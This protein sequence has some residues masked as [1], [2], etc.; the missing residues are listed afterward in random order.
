MKLRVFSFFFLIRKYNSKNFKNITGDSSWKNKCK[1]KNISVGF[2]SFYSWF[3]IESSISQSIYSQGND[4]LR[5]GVFP[6][7]RA[8][9]SPLFGLGRPFLNVSIWG[10]SH[11]LL[12]ESS[13]SS[14][15]S[16][17]ESWLF[18]NEYFL[19]FYFIRNTKKNKDRIFRN[20]PNQ[21]SCKVVEITWSF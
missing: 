9:N 12:L 13:L 16:S 21:K 2:S 3:Y 15:S 17:L 14:S 8:R 11:E 4:Y 19:V 7:N 1:L 5:H 6:S 18:W 20:I 10:L